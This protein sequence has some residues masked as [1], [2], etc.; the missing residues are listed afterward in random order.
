MRTCT[1]V[2]VSSADRALVETFDIEGRAIF[3]EAKTGP[4][5][6]LVIEFPDRAPG[7][8]IEAVAKAINDLLDAV[9]EVEGAARD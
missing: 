9:R 7:D 5:S 2:Y 1:R 4:G 3:I 6:Q 8:R